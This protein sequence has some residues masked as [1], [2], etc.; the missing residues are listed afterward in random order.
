MFCDNH[1]R[2]LMCLF[3]ELDTVN[4]S[5]KMWS[6][7]G[8]F[9]RLILIQL[10][11]SEPFNYYFEHNCTFEML[12]NVVDSRFFRCRGVSLCVDR[13]KGILRDVKAK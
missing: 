12:W 8:C 4:P 13:I 2:Y 3:T 10:D 1:I 7:G 11:S 5:M 6:D 9:R